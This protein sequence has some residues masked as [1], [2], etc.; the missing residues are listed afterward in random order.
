V[1][2]GGEGYFLRELDG[3]ARREWSRRATVSLDKKFFR[4]MMKKPNRFQIRSL[5]GQ[6]H[7]K[8]AGGT[9]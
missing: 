8:K 7:L 2:E 3:K 1:L 4:F 5:Y 9:P 6:M